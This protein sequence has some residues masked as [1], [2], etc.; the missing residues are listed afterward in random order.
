[1]TA[2]N[3]NL[4]EIHSSGEVGKN[5]SSLSGAVRASSETFSQDI[6]GI[7]TA[8]LVMTGNYFDLI[9]ACGAQKEHPNM[10]DLIKTNFGV[11]RLDGTL[12]RATLTFKGC[13]S[14]KNYIRYTLDSNTQAK[15]IDTHPFF[16]QGKDIPDGQTIITADDAYGY[17]FGDRVE[18]G[19]PSGS[20]QAV[21]DETQLSPV[22]KKFP[23]NAQYDLPGV[24]QYFGIG[25]TLNVIIVSH[26]DDGFTHQVEKAIDKGGY[27]FRVGMVVDPPSNIKPDIEK[28]IQT[29][30]DVAHN[31]NWLITRCNIEVIGSA[32]RQQVEFTLS[33]YR[34]WNKL[35]YN[36]DTSAS[37]PSDNRHEKLNMVQ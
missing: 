32:I 24:Q 29:A 25:M 14:G 13:E 2:K 37:P 10:Q 8:T 15:G 34:G 5:V 26:A 22:F 9:E 4:K 3:N 21:Y 30:G 19:V 17:R 16:Q 11:Q 31:Y 7:S 12:G 27:C 18:G 33:G 20:K 36:S 1:M 23:V 6:D 35:I 28:T